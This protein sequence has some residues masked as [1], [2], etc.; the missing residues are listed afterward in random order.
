MRKNFIIR[1]PNCSWSKLTT[2][3]SE[4]LK[5]MTEVRKCNNCG[6]PREFRCPKCGRNSKMIRMK[7]NT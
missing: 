4:D 6:R 1:C 2:G 7:G 3:L 5:D